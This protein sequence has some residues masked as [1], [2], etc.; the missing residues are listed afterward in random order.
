MI[1]TPKMYQPV[2]KDL[3]KIVEE[4]N[5][6]A[7]AM[8]FDKYGVK[9]I[10]FTEAEC[11]TFGLRAGTSGTIEVRIFKDDRAYRGP[12]I[13]DFIDRIN[14]YA[15]SSQSVKD[16]SDI[17]KAQIQKI[18]ESYLGKIKNEIKIDPAT[19]KLMDINGAIAQAEKIFADAQKEL[20]EVIYPDKIGHNEEAFAQAVSQFKQLTTQYIIERGRPNIVS[21]FPDGSID[22]QF[23]KGTKT[24]PGNY[25][26]HNEEEK[27]GFNPNAVLNVV[28][29][30]RKGQ[31]QPVQVK[32]VGS[33]AASFSVFIRDKEERRRLNRI[34]AE[35]DIVNYLEGLGAKFTDGQEVMIQSTSLLSPLKSIQDKFAPTFVK[36]YES[37]TRQLED[38]HRALLLLEGKEIE[39]GG[40][41][42]KLK[43]NHVNFSV[44]DRRKFES[45]PMISNNDVIGRI[46]SIGF[47]HYAQHQME[48]LEKAFQGRKEEGLI[49][50]LFKKL[51]PEEKYQE[52]IKKYEKEMN[53][54]YGQG[55][56]VEAK[57]IEV[58]L[59]NLYKEAYKHLKEID[60]SLDF[61]RLRDAAKHAATPEEHRAFNQ[62]L[63]F[64][65]VQKQYYSGDYKQYPDCYLFAAQFIR[66]GELSGQFQFWNCKTTKDRSGWVADHIKTLIDIEEDPSPSR[67]KLPLLSTD[68]DKSDFLQKLAKNHEYGASLEAT[69][70]N[71]R[72]ARGNRVGNMTVE[73]P[74][75]NH[76]P[77]M[78]KLAK[79]KIEIP[80]VKEIY[81]R[82]AAAGSE[83]DNT[84]LESLISDLG[85]ERLKNIF[86]NFKG[87][88]N[89]FLKAA[90]ISLLS[91]KGIDLPADLNFSKIVE[92][93]NTLFSE[94]AVMPRDFRINYKKFLE[95]VKNIPGLNSLETSFIVAIV[96]N[97]KV[98]DKITSISAFPPVGNLDQAYALTRSIGAQAEENDKYIKHLSRAIAFIGK[99]DEEKADDLYDL[100]EKLEAKREDYENKLAKL[101]KKIEA[102]RGRVPLLDSRQ[103]EASNFNISSSRL[104]EISKTAEKVYVFET[105]SDGTL[106]KTEKDPQHV[107]AEDIMD[108]PVVYEF[109]TK[110]TYPRKVEASIDEEV[111][112]HMVERAIEKFGAKT[113]ADLKFDGNAKLVKLAMFIAAE[114]LNP[115]PDDEL[116]VLSADRPTAAAA[117]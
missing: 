59:S 31:P 65:D 51:G 46:T 100:M 54:L 75:K 70:K 112:K 20:M 60:F 105:K 78:S 50:S 95:I 52:K 47:A 117:A 40:V 25:R 62:L 19:G 85:D 28:A 8:A 114:K 43:I 11:K 68:A 76:G 72:G 22:A 29:V 110:L 61:I 93:I 16:L 27:E 90:I 15:E 99:V 35:R 97:N 83:S 30:Q 13:E 89:G 2:E 9:T 18:K 80:S 42:V 3:S 107:V 53:A 116:S 4:T 94:K 38:H 26:S 111:V 24:Y 109:P 74:A 7:A 101:D 71:S 87:I 45:H 23:T 5:K 104:K 79:I 77:N 37:E 115:R 10:A 92:N 84:K 91:D 82:L 21:I 81:K 56:H 12:A 1:E 44:K 34:N 106:R 17:Q 86:E 98:E 14:F 63:Y 6:K 36:G 102:F 57:K 88:K 33:R 32:F 96:S 64:L 103:S 41:K 39:V 108:K 49:K 73:G 55:K 58:K 66:S 48:S 113:V 67:E 69:A